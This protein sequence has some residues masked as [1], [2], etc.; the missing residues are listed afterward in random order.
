MAAQHSAN[1]DVDRPGAA[2]G[3]P[4]LGNRPPP[5]VLKAWAF[6][7]RTAQR[8]VSSAGADVNQ[9]GA[10]QGEQ[11]PGN[12]PP[13]EVVLQQTQGL[14][15]PKAAPSADRVHPW[16]SRTAAVVDRLTAE[17][18]QVVEAELHHP[19]PNWATLLNITWLGGF[20]NVL[21]ATVERAALL[22]LPVAVFLA[23]Y[24]GKMGGLTFEHLLAV[25]VI[26]WLFSTAMH[27]LQRGLGARS[28]PHFQV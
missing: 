27:Q 26:H 24:Q 4:L 22:S 12:Q 23:H 16:I 28:G 13:P 14:V 20:L 21:H 10:A 8:A 15:L 5:E 9:P 7:L 2:Q 17:I 3:E 19:R 25:F 18:L 1:A 11:L 6:V